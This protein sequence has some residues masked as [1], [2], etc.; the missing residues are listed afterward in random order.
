MTEQPEDVLE[1]L[2]RAIAGGRLN[3]LLFSNLS[4]AHTAET[5]VTR[6]DVDKR[7]LSIIGAADIPAEARPDRPIIVQRARRIDESATLSALQGIGSVELARP[8][9]PGLVAL[10]KAPVRRAY[11]LTGS[12]ILE[13]IAREAFSGSSKGEHPQIVDTTVNR[14][15]PSQPAL[16]SSP[17]PNAQGAN[18]AASLGDVWLNRLEA[19]LELYDVLAIAERGLSPSDWKLV[20]DAALANRTVF[21]VVR[22]DQ[23]QPQHHARAAVW[24]SVH[25]IVVDSLATFGDEHLASRFS[26]VAEGGNARS[27]YYRAGSPEADIQSVATLLARGGSEVQGLP[28]FLRGHDP[29]WSDIAAGRLARRSLVDEVVERIAAAREDESE[30]SH[31]STLLVGRAGSGKT[32]SIMSIAAG[33]ARRHGMTGV[34]INRGFLGAPGQIAAAATDVD[35][36]AIDDLEIFGADAF[37]VVKRCQGSGATVIASIRSNREWRLLHSMPNWLLHRETTD[38]RLSKDEL[39]SLYETLVLEEGGRSLFSLPTKSERLDKLAEWSE[40][41]L[42]SALIRVVHDQRLI[43]RVASELDEIGARGPVNVYV[44]V[45]LSFLRTIFSVRQVSID[46]VVQISRRFDAGETIEALETL[47][48]GRLIS[49][50]DN[51][52]TAR[53]RT[54]SDKVVETLVERDHKSKSGDRTL[55]RVHRDLLAFYASTGADEDDPNNPY[56][57]TL[58]QLASHRLMVDLQYPVAHVRALYQSIRKDMDEDYHYWLQ[59]ASF[60][61]EQGIQGLGEA[62][63]HIESA[64]SLPAGRRSSAVRTEA[65][66]VF[67]RVSKADPDDPEA[68]ARALNAVIDLDAVSGA[69]GK[70]SP[71]TFT[72]ALKE[73]VDWL[74]KSPC[75]S[76]ADR[77][78]AIRLI[79]QIK[80]RAAALH[81]QD[82][83]VEYGVVHSKF[84]ASVEQLWREAEPFRL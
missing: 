34:W 60:E 28:L 25:T 58:I 74:G 71:H 38:H 80:D 69:A 16:V 29:T 39:E 23:V 20:E 22:G 81:L 47:H 8:I 50:D 76:D 75:L 67:L 31:A 78:N 4:E 10:L 42:L 43:D 62:V 63:R 5:S 19:D 14:A 44:Y 13:K 24:P 41:D 2:H 9:P 70:T 57:R 48:R 54:I 32:A 45:A 64:V 12:R 65:G 82:D 40:H 15:A 3:L 1:N 17:P 68:A 51:L 27:R 36:V 66:R 77:A 73:G 52:V 53:H 55:V 46:D 83:N 11:D 26:W 72:V 7:L 49:M 37:D 30:K 79:R 21:V 18:G 59:Q 33:L 61:V 35:F 56:R 6:E 84:A